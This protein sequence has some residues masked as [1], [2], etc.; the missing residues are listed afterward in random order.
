MAGVGGVDDVDQERCEEVERREGHGEREP[1]VDS[2]QE[3]AVLVLLER[4]GQGG[5]HECGGEA[6]HQTGEHECAE[7]QHEA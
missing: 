5:G 1:H 7:V 2:K 4:G 3:G 6:G